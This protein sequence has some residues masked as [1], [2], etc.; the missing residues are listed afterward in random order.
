MSPHDTGLSPDSLALTFRARCFPGFESANSPWRRTRSFADPTKLHRRSILTTS[1]AGLSPRLRNRRSF[2][3]RTSWWRKLEV[4]G[5]AQLWHSGKAGPHARSPKSCE[6]K[7]AAGILILASWSSTAAAVVTI[8]PANPSTSDLITIRVENRYNSEASVTSA[9]INQTGN[10]FTIE[11]NVLLSCLLPNSPTLVSEF[12]V[13]PLNPGTYAVT[14]HINM[15][16]QCTI[17]TSPQTVTFVVVESIPTLNSYLL[18]MLAGVF[19]V[20]AV[21][22]M[23]R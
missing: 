5:I 1:S 22:S 15:N 19:G 21:L 3:P 14:A 9:S 11:Q 17:V 8:S 2:A 7:R 10:S 16:A 4:S 18:I 12:E 20:V 6:L 13:G 23:K